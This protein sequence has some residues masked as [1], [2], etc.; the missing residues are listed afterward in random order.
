MSKLPYFFDP[1]DA[2][3]YYRET[4][5]ISDAARAYVVRTL[6]RD[7][8]TNSKIRETLGIEKVYTVTHLKR[9][10]CALS[11]E[12]L[13]LW[14]KNSS[15]ITLG[16]VRAIAKLPPERIEE[17][18]RKVISHK[19]SVRQV[20][21]LAKGNDIEPASDIKTYQ[22]AVSDAIGR[23]VKVS[24][25]ESTCCGSITLDFYGLDDLDA[26]TKALGYSNDEEPI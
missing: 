16:H 6:S 24:Y 23:P 13:M 26:I 7:G 2:I 19:L 11:E 21:D 5:R 1:Q 20:I 22:E 8:Y 4:P 14:D 15:R 25:S 17:I 9:T 10:G 3:T 18:L 12:Q